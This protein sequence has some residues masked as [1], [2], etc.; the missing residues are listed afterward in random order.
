[1]LPFK[2]ETENRKPRPFPLIRLSFAHCTNGSVS[3][4]RLFTKKQTA[5]I[6][7]QTE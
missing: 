4:V 5:V 3:F 2:T 6:R 1:M 7:L